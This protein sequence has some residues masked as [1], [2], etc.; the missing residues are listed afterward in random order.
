MQATPTRGGTPWLLAPRG[1]GWHYSFPRSS[2]LSPS[3]RRGAETTTS[4]RRSR[5]PPWRGPPAAPA[6][7]PGSPRAPP[8]GTF[9]FL[10][11]NNAIRSVSPAGAVVTLAGLPGTAGSTDN[12]AGNANVRISFPGGDA[13]HAGADPFV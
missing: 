5:S 4:G 7:C 10:C 3:R 1:C 8:V 12:P 11:D 6:S 13:P 9:L 2:L